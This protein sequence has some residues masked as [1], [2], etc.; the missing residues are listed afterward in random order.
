MD[1]TGNKIVICQLQ[2]A[3]FSFESPAKFMLGKN[4]KTNLL[5]LCIYT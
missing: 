1:D 5:H 2:N 4:K 3:K